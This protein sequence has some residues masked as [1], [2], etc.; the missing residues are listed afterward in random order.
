MSDIVLFLPGNL[1]H[2]NVTQRQLKRM[3]DEKAGMDVLRNSTVPVVFAWQRIDELLAPDI[4][5]AGQ[6][7]LCAGSLTHVLHHRLP[8]EDSA[9]QT[10]KGTKGSGWHK[11]EGGTSIDVT[12][13]PEF[14]PPADPELIPT[15]FFFLSAPH[16]RYYDHDSTA[17]T[18]T[19]AGALPMA[20]A[21][22]FR[23][24]V[25]ILIGNRILFDNCSHPIRRRWHDY[26]KDPEKGLE[27]LIQA[28][29]KVASLDGRVHIASWDLETPYVGSEI[30]ANILWREYLEALD[31][32]RLTSAFSPLERHLGWFSKQ[33]V[34]MATPHRLLAKWTRH[35]AQLDYIRRAYDHPSPRTPSERERWL[36]AVARCSDVLSVMDSKIQSQNK[37]L[38]AHAVTYRE[39]VLELGAACLDS[40]EETGQSLDT[41]SMADPLLGPRLAKVLRENTC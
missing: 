3:L 31:K 35:D 4:Y 22:R 6:H 23:S 27:P 20:P 32:K 38:P 41:L 39:G 8:R 15:G 17:A 11:A 30:D 36:L 37:D 7:E 24:K 10:L 40:V 26:Q 34:E 19:V 13:H 29:E 2:S 33:A 21:I 18:L 14:A 1:F 28:T 5:D 9:W 16:T 25:G 12:F